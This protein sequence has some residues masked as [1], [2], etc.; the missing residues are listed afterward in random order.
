MH[1]RYLTAILILAVLAF[2][3]LL[4]LGGSGSTTPK[5]SANLTV[6]EL[7]LRPNAGP[8]PDLLVHSGGKLIGIT[9]EASQQWLDVP[10]K[11]CAAPKT[12]DFQP[13]GNTIA[14]WD[15]G[16][17]ADATN[18]SLARYP[19]PTLETAL[20]LPTTK[21]GAI[22]LSVEDVFWA[23]DGKQLGV[24]LR[25]GA[26]RAPLLSGIFLN[27]Q[28]TPPVRKLL[29]YDGKTLR[30]LTRLP[31]VSEVKAEWT[32]NGILASDNERQLTIDPTSGKI[33]RALPLLDHFQTADYRSGYIAND[34]NLLPMLDIP[35]QTDP[36]I[37]HHIVFPSDASLRDQ[38][39]T[40]DG[41]VYLVNRRK[42]TYEPKANFSDIPWRIQTEVYVNQIWRWKE[43]S[44]E[45]QLL[46]EYQPNVPIE[47]IYWKDQPDQLYAIENTSNSWLVD[48]INLTNGDRQTVY[49]SHEPVSFSNVS[50]K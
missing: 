49:T 5:T 2:G 17:G 47:K 7:D 15:T 38:Q 48:Q 4:L 29:L 35:S 27:S 43:G 37:S 45:P 32:T 26:V 16:C 3:A 22:D 41:V 46:A 21:P 36:N 8:K 44:S 39:T 30:L 33:T 14:L 12:T 9:G 24:I 28:Y 50:V 1:N 13:G 34:D 42:I 31:A 25:E 11:Y 19:S 40:T 6:N 18:L 23:P 20:V 10:T